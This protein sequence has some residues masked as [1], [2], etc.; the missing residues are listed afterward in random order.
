MSVLTY[1]LKL[2]TSAF[3]GPMAAASGALRG[4]TGAA[5]AAAGTL[6]KLAPAAAAISSLAGAA[7]TLIGVKHAFDFG[8][9]LSDLSARTATGVRDL[10]ILGRAFR[11][12]GMTADATGIRLNQ[13][14]KALA[15]V[16][17]DGE[18]T[19]EGFRQLGLDME[20]LRKLNPIQQFEELGAAIRKIEDPAKRASASM[21]IFGRG[22]GEM[23]TLLMDPEAWR[24]AEQAMGGMAEILDRNAAKFD[25]ASDIIGGAW[26]KMRGYFVGFSAE[27]VDGVLAPLEAFQ[28]MDL[29][30]LGTQVGILVKTLGSGLANLT[31]MQSAME[32][33]LTPLIDGMVLKMQLFN[34]KVAGTMKLL[35]AAKD[36]G[37]LGELIGA[38]LKV[39]VIESIN[40][41]SGGIRSSV[42]YLGGSLPAIFSAAADLLTSPGLVSFMQNLFRGVGLTIRSE[43]EYGAAA[44][45][46]AFGE[47]DLSSALE[48]ASR[49]SAEWA[50]LKF[51]K[52][53]SGLGNADF[54]GALDKIGK[55]LTDAHAAGVEAARAATAKPLID[56]KLARDQ[57]K[58]LAGSLDPKALED[59]LKNE[60]EG[61]AGQVKSLKDS[62]AK[63]STAAKEA[64]KPANQ[65]G[66]AFPVAQMGQP[67]AAGEAER[68]R[69][70]NAEQTG[71]ARQARLLQKQATRPGYFSNAEKI[72]L[73][74]LQRKFGSIKLA[75]AAAKMG[76][77][78]AAA[79]PNRGRRGAAGDAALP[80]PLLKLV[81]GIHDRFA[82]L[83]TA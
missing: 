67:E 1:A 45:L 43:L 36:Q 72:E 16:N 56:P 73:E 71:L 32:G 35:A 62:L 69:F 47:T 68:K 83:A 55:A 7:A 30:G 6:A 65:P 44:I 25:R 29:S 13:M 74:N 24:N 48:Q 2:N 33:G 80:D 63:M 23:L 18:S 19:S 9:E 22:G 57:W 70:R 15:G 75:D 51:E 14:Q 49:T 5:G 41:L 78:A 28:A 58:E 4:F 3:T 8:G 27:I 21:G 46:R 40:L 59:I 11:D 17:E 82:N 37:K 50:G 66:G 10:V 34:Q 77:G 81:Q 53:G 79:D 64:A 42:A 76:R 12:A 54:A 38:S 52:A 39:G 20:A 61:A 31:G 26:D 60:V